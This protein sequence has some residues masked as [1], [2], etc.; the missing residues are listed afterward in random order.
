MRLHHRQILAFLFSLFLMP[1]G[2]LAE[3]DAAATCAGKLYRSKREGVP[4]FDEPATTGDVITRLKLGEKVCWIGERDNFAIISSGS[5]TERRVHYIKTFDLWPP[6]DGSARHGSVGRETTPQSLLESAKGHM[7]RILQGVPSEDP[8]APYRDVLKPS[9]DQQP[10]D[11]PHS[12]DFASSQS[13]SW[14]SSLPR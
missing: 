13:S 10:T 2:S 3:D 5:G 4:V 7:R 9:L 1:V 6:R 11:S 14:S 8:L 12:V